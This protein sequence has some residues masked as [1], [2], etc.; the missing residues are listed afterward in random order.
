LRDVKKQAS[1]I[2][3]RL[4]EAGYGE[5]AVI[6]AKDLNTK[7]TEIEGE[8]T[9]LKGEGGQDSL[10]FPGRLDNQFVVLYGAIAGPDAKPRPGDLERFEDLKPQLDKLLNDLQHVY[11]T[12]LDSFNELVR[13]KGVPAV[14][15]PR[16]RAT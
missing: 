8:L 14:I 13:S 2:A 11:A 4:E 7:L 1:D 15:I 5:E 9:Q 3:A 12:E 16:K 6:A 10:N